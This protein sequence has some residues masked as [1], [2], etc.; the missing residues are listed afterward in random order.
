MKY[1][2]SRK[3]VGLILALLLSGTS[4]IIV[5][6]L[7]DAA[8]QTQAS[9]LGGNA[10]LDN[11]FIQVDEM[12]AREFLSEMVELAQKRPE[13]NILAH[14]PELLTR[15]AALYQYEIGESQRLLIE[16]DWFDSPSTGTLD[17][18]IRATALHAAGVPELA[19]MQCLEILASEASP[20]WRELAWDGWMTM[21]LKCIGVFPE[22]IGD[23]MQKAAM[24]VSAQTL[25]HMTAQLLFVGPLNHSD[26]VK[27]RVVQLIRI[28]YDMGFVEDVCALIPGMDSTPGASTAFNLF[29]PWCAVLNTAPT[30][31]VA[32]EWDAWLNAIVAAPDGPA[33]EMALSVLPETMLTALNL[34]QA[35]SNLIVKTSDFLTGL[36]NGSYHPHVL[37]RID[38]ALSFIAMLQ[39]DWDK[40]LEHRLTAQ[41]NLRLPGWFPWIESACSWGQA[42]EDSAWP[43]YVAMARG[44]TQSENLL[45]QWL[46]DHPYGPVSWRIYTQ[47]GEQSCQDCNH[48]IFQPRANDNIKNTLYPPE[49]AWT[50][51]VLATAP[52]LCGMPVLPADF[53]GCPELLIQRL[54]RM[55]KGMIW[56]LM[57][58]NKSSDSLLGEISYAIQKN[59]ALATVAALQDLFE[60][61]YVENENQRLDMAATQSLLALGGAELRTLI[62][63][64]KSLPVNPRAMAMHA[65][66]LCAQAC[67]GTFST[68]EAI[69]Q[70]HAATKD[71][72]MVLSGQIKEQPED[73]ELLKVQTVI[74]AQALL[75]AEKTGNLERDTV[76]FSEEFLAKSTPNPHAARILWPMALREIRHA[77]SA[78][79][80]TN[81]LA[82]LDRFEEITGSVQ[83]TGIDFPEVDTAILTAERLRILL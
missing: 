74:L 51:E 66:A 56:P 6:V 83:K 65:A 22:E 12:S 5:G 40:T 19:A 41:R 73:T 48:E 18:W 33:L 1:Y 49:P 78:N 53:S 26:D 35:D 69:E 10:S 34:A 37:A 16:R 39:Q 9:Q 72:L 67:D 81:A 52:F 50:G 14:R 25:E 21:R 79:D 3:S 58:Q 11:F 20:E 71:Y 17:T 82:W 77:L 61:G 46:Q 13:T 32:Q 68:A 4:F 24:E 28:R 42:Q 29:L 2:F 64:V 54:N 30:R 15:F 76:L 80:I 57:Q 7:R 36:M 60:S 8:T 38:E 44:D 45:V 23:W 27:G 59:D 43:I 47:Y 55:V 31:P 75:L 63:R 70:A 62:E